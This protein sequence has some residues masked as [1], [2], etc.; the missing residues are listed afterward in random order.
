MSDQW[1]V[2]REEFG[3]T[4]YEAVRCCGALMQISDYLGLPDLSPKLVAHYTAQLIREKAHLTK[5]ML[6][7]SE[8]EVSRLLLHYPWIPKL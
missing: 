6:A 8:E 1:H 4:L 7:L 3:L 5:A 2:T